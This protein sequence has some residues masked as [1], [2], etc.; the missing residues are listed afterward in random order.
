MLPGGIPSRAAFFVPEGRLEFVID[1]LQARDN[2]LTNS[3]RV[4]KYYIF[5][6][7]ETS[8]QNQGGGHGAETT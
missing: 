8:A 1:K 3:G 4:P 5:D 7:D 6:K 2:F